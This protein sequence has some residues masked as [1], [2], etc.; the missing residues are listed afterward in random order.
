MRSRARWIGPC[1]VVLAAVVLWLLLLA[2]GEARP[3]AT[4]PR[5]GL[6]VSV[7]VR[8]S[9]RP[10]S[11]GR[12]TALIAVGRATLAYPC[13]SALVAARQGAVLAARLRRIAVTRASLAEVSEGR[14]DDGPAL[15]WRGLVVAP[16]T[17]AQ[18]RLAGLSTADALVAIWVKALHAAARDDRPPAVLP[19]E[20]ALGVGDRRVVALPSAWAGAAMAGQDASRAVVGL[21]GA[22]LTLQGKSAG[23]VVLRLQ[24]GT[25]S[26]DVRVRVLDPAGRLPSSV[27]AAVAGFDPDAEFLDDACL[28]AVGQSTTRAPGASL[29]VYGQGGRPTVGVTRTF[30]SWLEGPGLWPVAGRVAV[31]VS[32]TTAAAGDVAWLAASNHP[33]RIDGAG[34]LLDTPTASGT[35]VFYF[36]HANAPR[37]PPRL[38]EVR[39]ENRSAA[40]VDLLV[41][42]SGA[43]PSRDELYAGHLATWRYMRWMLRGNGL[44]IRLAPRERCVLDLRRLGPRDVACGVGTVSVLRGTPPSLVVEASEMG[45]TEHG[46]EESSPVPPAAAAVR[47]RGLFGPPVLDLP[48]V[49]TVDGPY[50]FISVGGPPYGE[51]LGDGSP[52]VGNYGV[53]HRIHLR[54]VNPTAQERKVYVVFAA[55]GG[56]ARGS[57]LIENRLVETPLLRPSALREHLLGEYVLPPGT[58]CTVD[59][60]VVP[61]P[62]SNYPVRIIA[63]PLPAN[64]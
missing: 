20:I 6:A 25:A 63:K 17:P 29:T 58:E 57:V 56:V 19:E 59:L 49:Y 61:E 53:D 39:L 34:I 28:R 1:G 5:F 11:G 54:L 47:G 9:V 50:A 12:A 38:L 4:A 22:L 13:A 14:S 15:V 45:P 32:A 41:M 24:K 43:G 55:G 31:A 8:W 16:A 35:G 21:S 64:Q 23:T 40:P 44:A 36:H 30:T 18:A 37:A 10:A 48:V 7:D 52:N 62:G 26:A 3:P 2:R 60:R 51:P 27:R 33:E 46:G 42:E